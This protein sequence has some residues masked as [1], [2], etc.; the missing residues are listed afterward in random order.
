[1]GKLSDR[2]GRRIPI[3]VGPMIGAVSL[4]AIPFVR[5]FPILLA[6]GLLC[7]FRHD[8]PRFMPHIYGLQTPSA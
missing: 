7:L 4:V 5:W 2:I 6:I 8:T 1:M 3:T